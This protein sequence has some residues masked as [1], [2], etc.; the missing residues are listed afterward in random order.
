MSRGSVA[1]VQCNLPWTSAKVS[2]WAAFG[3]CSHKLQTQNSDKK[4]SPDHPQPSLLGIIQWLAFLSSDVFRIVMFEDLADA[5]SSLV[6]AYMHSRNLSVCCLG[7]VQL[8]LKGTQVVD[9]INRRCIH[10]Q[11]QCTLRLVDRCQSNLCVCAQ[12]GSGLCACAY[13]WEK[14]TMPVTA[15]Q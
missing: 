11:F 1:K 2:C 12:R 14:M 15:K 4:I 5:C 6:Y 7:S 10:T 13:Q 9:K 8:R 3:Y